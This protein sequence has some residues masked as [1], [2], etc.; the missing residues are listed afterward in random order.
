MKAILKFPE[1][2]AKVG[3]LAKMDNVEWY[4]LLT[5]GVLWAVDQVD[6]RIL[7]QGLERQTRIVP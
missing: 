4:Q 7:H 5:G 6:N 3:K 1:I 2:D